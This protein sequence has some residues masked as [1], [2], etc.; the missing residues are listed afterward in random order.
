MN[1]NLASG[2]VQEAVE[3]VEYITSGEPTALAK[4]RQANGR[5]EPWQVDYLGIGNESWACGGAMSADTYTAL[6]K[7]YAMMVRSLH[8]EQMAPNRFI[9]SK[10][11]MM[12]VAVGPGE[13]E[14]YEDY[15][16]EVMKSWKNRESRWNIEGLSLHRYTMGPRGAMRDPSTDFGESDYAAFVEQTYGMEKFIDKHI[17][18]MDQ[19]DPERKVFLA[20]DE[21]GVWLQ[22]MPNTNPLF[23]KQQNS[24]RDAVVAALHLNMFIR[25]A[26]R[27]KLANVAQLANVL[28]SMVLTDGKKML[29]TPTYYIFKMYVPFQDAEALPITLQQGQYTYKDI[30]LPQVDGIAAKAKDGHIYV[31]L[32]NIDPNRS[33]SVTVDI[34]G[35][36][37]T[38]ASGQ[39]LTAPTVDA[40]N[41]F[42][43]PTSVIP[44]TIKADA[45]N[46]QLILKLP[47][48]SIS[49]LRLE[50]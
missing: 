9:P 48:K 7:R 6:M 12:R 1:V 35:L 22:P 26:E 25:K 11:P 16:E 15:T 32:T 10:T 45:K 21:W 41:T 17:A 44:A 43:K 39:L 20:V 3:W 13:G 33:A 30:E 47:P 36:K 19:Y 37:P 42:D 40:V 34:K 14:N 5:K 24:L 23:L 28:Q 18:I 38:H 46:G 8:P 27:I 4:E 50:E 29:L 49:V 2:T 31:A